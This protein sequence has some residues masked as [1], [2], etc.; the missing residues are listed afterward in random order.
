[1]EFEEKTKLTDHPLENMFGITEGTTETTYKEALPSTPVVAPDYD[2]K[3]KD[4]E[5]QLET[6]YITA[7][8]QVT[9]IGDEM[10]KV[11]GKYKAR[12]GEVTATMLNV[13]LS[14]IREKRQMKEHKDKNSVAKA[15]TGPSTVNN[16]VILADRNEILRAL[17]VGKKAQD[18]I[19]EGEID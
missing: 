9:I 4:I 19:I 17:A 8:T 13:A 3:D 7:M 12:I 6:V 16:N 15:A 1:M 18:N 5:D 2:E 14:S 10:E 11:E